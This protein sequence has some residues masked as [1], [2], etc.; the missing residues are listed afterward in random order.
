MNVKNDR[1]VDPSVEGSYRSRKKMNLPGKSVFHVFSQDSIVYS[2]FYT[3][4]Q[5]N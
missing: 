4:K 1:K 3:H 5:Q 2:A